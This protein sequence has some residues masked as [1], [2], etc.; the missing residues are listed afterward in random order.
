MKIHHS[1]NVFSLI[2]GCKEPFIKQKCF[3][4]LDITLLYIYYSVFW[5]NGLHGLPL[6]I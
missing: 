6:Q 1:S 4:H 3:I 2:E 5:N